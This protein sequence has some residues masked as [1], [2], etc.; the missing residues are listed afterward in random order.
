MSFEMI[1]G[2]V[3]HFLTFVGGWVVARGVVDEATMTEA[4]G[5]SITIAGVVW[6]FVQKYQASKVE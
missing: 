4:V 6:S 5:A 1:M 3:R 2:F